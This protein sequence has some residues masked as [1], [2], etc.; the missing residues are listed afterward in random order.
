FS[1]QSQFGDFSNAFTQALAIIALRRT[2]GGVPASAVDF[3]AGTQCS[4]GVFPLDFGVTPCASDTDAT[5]MVTQALLA[6]GRIG[7]A[8]EGLTWL[9]SRQ[10]ANGGLSFGPGDPTVAPN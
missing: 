6:T 10:Q 3:A 7:D 5:A 2:P 9:A 4:D 1:D 8:Q